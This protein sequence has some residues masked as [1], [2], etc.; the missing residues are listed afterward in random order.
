MNVSSRSRRDEY[1][2]ATRRALLDSATAL[3]GSRGY[4][5][6]SLEQVAADARVTKGAV[7]HH[8][9]SKQALF[10]EVADEQDTLVRDTAMAAIRSQ[11][12]TWD[13]SIAGMDAFL[14]LCLDPV[15][16]RLVFL[17]GPVA[18]GFH[19]WWDCATGSRELIRAMLDALMAEGTIDPQPADV[20][21]EVMFGCLNSM[22]L[23][24]AR[25]ENKDLVRRQAGQ[26][27]RRIL[28]GLRA[29]A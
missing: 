22:A 27:M 2:D 11:S 13:A 17:E 10:M 26:V 9:P 18:I 3:F 15:F 19:G 28:G 6:T 20:L 1:A 7:Y 16:V 23:L 24:I 8:F 14:D 21:T 4:A 5:A 12:T 25:S 29:P